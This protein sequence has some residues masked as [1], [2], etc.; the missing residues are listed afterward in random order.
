MWNSDSAGTVQS[1]TSGSDVAVDQV[2]SAFA[3]TRI[4]VLLAL[5]AL[6]QAQAGAD[7]PS[8][9]VS[10]ETLRTQEKAQQLFESGN[11]SRAYFI[12]RNELAPLGD[13]YS[14]YMIGF[15]Y[16]TGKGVSIDGIAASA[17]YRLAAERATPEFVKARDQVLALLTPEQKAASDRE[18]VALRRELADVALLLKAVQSDYDRIA[19]PNARLRTATTR[20]LLYGI[21]VSRD[22]RPLSDQDKLLIRKRLQQRMDFI[23]DTA[24]IEVDDRDIDSLD[25]SLIEAQVNAYLEKID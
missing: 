16:L 3:R 2:N 18:Y 15:M 19:H 25:L 10:A 21:G 4:V 7:V 23:L 11:Y 8:M 5:A 13:K 1:D 12:Y 14:Q 17:W 6:L 20:E 9:P 22:E 24:Q